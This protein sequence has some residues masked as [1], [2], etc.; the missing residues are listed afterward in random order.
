MLISRAWALLWLPLAVAVLPQDEP[1]TGTGELTGRIEIAGPGGAATPAAGAVLWLP[2]QP[3]A[4]P[5]T[6]S[7]TVTQKDKRFDPHVL[8]VSKRTPV[9]FPNL[10]KIFHNVF[11]LSP[12]NE[13]DLGLYRG[14]KSK[15]FQL[16]APGL[17]RIYC[18]IHAQMA[19]YVMVL[20]GS[21]AYAVTDAQGRY[22]IA[23]IREGRREVRV[24]HERSGEHTASVEVVHGRAATLDL[25][26][27]ATSRLETAHKNKYGEDY[28]PVKDD[29]DRY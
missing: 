1:Q 24:W 22:R 6:A 20:D 14:G 9:H 5:V 25:S 17:V 29:A 10:D 7:A 13:F 8:V 12:G 28:P 2:G 4:A 23:G 15:D 16:N 19:A 11:S 3:T 26:L 18:N 27:D 21:W